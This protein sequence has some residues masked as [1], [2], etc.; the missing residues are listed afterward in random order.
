MTTPFRINIVVDQGRAEANLNRVERRLSGLEKQGER[1]SQTLGRAFRFIASGF[2]VRQIGRTANAY[3]EV[4][5]RLRTVTDGSE[6]LADVQQR[7]FEIASETRQE[8][9][10]TAEVFARVGLS[11]QELGRSQEELLQFTE[12]LNKAVALSGASSQ[13]AQAGLIQLSQGLASGAL[14]GDELR[15]VLEQLPVVADVIARSIGVTRGELRELGAEGKISADIVLD[16][17]KEARG[18]LDERFGETVP[19]LAQAFTELRNEFTQVVGEIEEGTGI[20]RTFGDG[21]RFAA[22]ATGEFRDILADLRAGGEGPEEQR[23]ITLQREIELR[24]QI[25]DELEAERQ[26][27]V[28]Q[29]EDTTALTNAIRGQFR[30][31]S[32]LVA[33]RRKLTE[34]S[35]A[36]REANQEEEA[37]LRPLITAENARIGIFQRLALEAGRLAAVQV[38]GARDEAIRQETAAIAEREQLLGL[39]EEQRAI[40][41]EQRRIIAELQ[42]RG[43]K[44][45]EDEIEAL[46][47]R[48]AAIH[49]AE[50]STTALIET[51]KNLR[52]VG[53]GVFE[54]IGD[55]AVAAATKGGQEFDKFLESTLKQ[56]Q[57]LAAQK[58]LLAILDA[59]TGGGASAGT[60]FFGAFQQRQFGGPVQRNRPV[61]VGER[62]P[63]IFTPPGAGRIVPAGE[64]AAIMQQQRS[65]AP[66]VNVTSPTPQVN[67]MLLSD[68]DEIP[69]G[70]ES[71]E[72]AQAVLTVLSRKKRQAKGILS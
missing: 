46:N 54:A 40:E 58:A 63:E 69:Q 53:Q 67:V 33:E 37:S 56:L 51:Q 29:G 47:D 35:K 36:Q 60:S 18:E 15:S 48:I 65:A 9:E 2:V 41:I 14:R 28:A 6:N 61:V 71:E 23:I 3:Q 13:E 64:T 21:V 5:N 1:T 24:K 38:S 17:F 16:A 68:P 52:D 49:E 55:T 62:G 8:Y 39:S 4:Q 43:V 25:L 70:I 44:L 59:A 19:T 42:A 22:Q 66:Q 7:L 12:S 30:T 20:F 10:A 11:A 27:R 72:G 50:N 57:Q 32:D 26:Q 34:T 31:L 45:T